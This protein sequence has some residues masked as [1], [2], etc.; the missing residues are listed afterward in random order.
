PRQ[1]AQPL[2]GCCRQKLH[3]HYLQQAAALRRQPYHWARGSSGGQC[4]DLQG[5]LPQLQANGNHA[6]GILTKGCCASTQPAGRPC[7][8]HGCHSSSP[9]CSSEGGGSGS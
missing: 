9:V 7:P 3:S 5:R 1:P 8:W 6:A 2:P 4:L